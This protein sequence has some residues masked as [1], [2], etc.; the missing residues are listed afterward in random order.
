ML[1]CFTYLDYGTDK[2]TSKPTRVYVEQGLPQICSWMEGDHCAVGLQSGAWVDTL[3]VIAQSR[4]VKE[5]SQRMSL[6]WVLTSAFVEWTTYIQST[7]TKA[8]SGVG[9]TNSQSAF[10]FLF[11]VSLSPN[12]HFRYQSKMCTQAPLGD[13]AKPST[14]ADLQELLDRL[15]GELQVV[16][17]TCFPLRSRFLSRTES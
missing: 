1:K 16:L 3:G 5:N 14:S 6:S 11:T 12:R 9:Y 8:H 4:T 10:S 13:T 7:L 15:A 2:E 17:H